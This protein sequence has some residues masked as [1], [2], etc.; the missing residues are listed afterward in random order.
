V[1]QPLQDWDRFWFAPRTTRALALTRITLGLAAVY[2]TLCY[3]P[4]LTLFFSDA[5]LITAAGLRE[6]EGRI[7]MS[8]LVWFGGGP[9]AVG[10]CWLALLAAALG[11]LL[12]WRTR[13]SAAALYLLLLTLQER[14]VFLL[15]GGDL[16]LR[17]LVFWFVFAPCAGGDLLSLDARRRAAA[18][19]GP[20][21]APVWAQR[22]LQL[23]VVFLYFSTAVWKSYNP[24]WPT[25]VALYYAFGQVGFSQAGL[26]LVLNYPYVCSLMTSAVLY[27]E[28]FIGPAL[29][30]PLT[31]RYALLA[32]LAL[33]LGI[34]IF[35]RVPAF[36]LVILAS[37]PCF[38]NE[39]EAR[40][41]EDWFRRHVL[42]RVS[43]LRGSGSL[44]VSL[45]ESP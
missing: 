17:D 44:D 43:A 18:G 13:L 45:E 29:L 5:G 33:H 39:A 40:A 42:A 21:E 25:G 35:M 9:W 32:G 22:M 38:L 34:M 23:Q 30:F 6:A 26:E 14:N 37:Y 19:K 36:S 16:L 12:G 24:D 10:V 8:P 15:N 31:R 7:N 28:Y 41:C 20:L 27:L 2:W 1:I 4:D 3:L 11:F